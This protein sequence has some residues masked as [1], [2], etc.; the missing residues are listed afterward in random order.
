MKTKILF[1]LAIICIFGIQSCQKEV[2][3]P[4]K[5]ACD[6]HDHTDTTTTTGST[7]T[8]PNSVADGAEAKLQI[9]DNHY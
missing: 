3:N 6:K 4:S 8:T 1:S 9:P 7:S 2:V 5:P